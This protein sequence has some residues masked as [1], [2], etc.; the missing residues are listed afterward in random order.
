LGRRLAA[1]HLSATRRSTAGCGPEGRTRR[2][3][4]HRVAAGHEA[5]TAAEARNVDIALPAVRRLN[6]DLGDVVA[7]VR[8][9][10]QLGPLSVLT[11][12]PLAVPPKRLAELTVRSV[13]ALVA[14]PTSPRGSPR[15][16]G[17]WQPARNR[18]DAIVHAARELFRSR[19]FEDVNLQDIAQAAG[20]SRPSVYHYFRNK[21]EILD[22]AW[23]R[24][25]ARFVVGTWTALDGAD[26]ADDALDRL[27]DAYTAVVLD[28]TDILGVVQRRPVDAPRSAPRHPPAPAPPARRRLG[29]GARR[30]PARPHRRRDPHPG[31]HGLQRRG[32]GCRGRRRRPRLAR[33]DRDHDGRLRPRLTCRGE[34]H[35]V[36]GEGR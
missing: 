36:E 35:Q 21:A 14:A 24:E 2:W 25:L 31:R 7:A 6:P 10:T 9:F 30:G 3:E 11:T 13:V 20:L 23:R 26:S 8:L 28:C 27:A 16:R 15:H 4:R 5:V 18:P 33:G 12:T 1:R 34:N 19:R 17:T 32:L 22:E 29:R